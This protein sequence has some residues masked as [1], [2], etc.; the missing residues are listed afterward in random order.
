MTRLAKAFQVLRRVAAALRQRPDVVNFLG[1]RN[2]SLLLA[3]LAER[4]RRA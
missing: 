1:R 3:V 2:P 4:M